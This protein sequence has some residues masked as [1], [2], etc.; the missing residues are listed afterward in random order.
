MEPHPK[1]ELNEA[2]AGW[3]NALASTGSLSFDIMRELE[4]HLRDSISRLT[5]AEPTEE[6]AFLIATRRVGSPAALAAEFR[7][8]KPYG[9]WVNWATAVLLGVQAANFL[10]QLVPVAAALLQVAVL[11]LLTPIQAGRFLHQPFSPMMW[12]S[13]LLYVLIVQLLLSLCWRMVRN[14]DIDVAAWLFKARQHPWKTGVLL[15]GLSF[16]LYLVRIVTQLVLGQP[17]FPFWPIYVYAFA[18]SLYLP[19]TVVWLLHR[20]L[21]QRAG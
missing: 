18:S 8:A 10:L 11:R 13:P 6:E 4:E 1:F 12:L 5:A 3:R 21:P 14:R 7:R 15:V 17:H 20:R 2:V 9:V 19:L 16:G